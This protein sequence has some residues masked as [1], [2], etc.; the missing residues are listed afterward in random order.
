MTK[1]ICSTG[2]WVARRRPSSGVPMV[3]FDRKDRTGL[4]SQ[5]VRLC[6]VVIWTW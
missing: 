5:V 2:I 3:R 4:L 6:V 1:G